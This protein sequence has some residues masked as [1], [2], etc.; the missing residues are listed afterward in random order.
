MSAFVSCDKPLS[1]F[2][3]GPMRTRAVNEIALTCLSLSGHLLMRATPIRASRL[4][5]SLT[6]TYYH[7]LY[8]PCFHNVRYAPLRFALSV[9]F[10]CSSVFTA[11]L[12]CSVQFLCVQYASGYAHGYGCFCNSCEFDHHALHCPLAA[13]SDT[14]TQAH[15]DCLV[16]KH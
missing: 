7:V 8:T 3:L 15:L 14:H 12:S 1:C 10:T 13:R 16:N 5:L 9:G 2:C 4:A 11:A 6:S